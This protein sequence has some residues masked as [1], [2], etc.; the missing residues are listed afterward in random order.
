MQQEA[1]IG[2]A[3]DQIPICIAPAFYD[4]GQDLTE[5]GGNVNLENA[6]HHVPC[7]FGTEG[8]SKMQEYVPIY[9][10]VDQYPYS[11]TPQAYDNGGG[12]SHLYIDIGDSDYACRYCNAMLESTRCYRERLHAILLDRQGDAIQANVEQQTLENK[13][14]LLVTRFTKFDPIPPTGFPNHYFRFV[15]YNRLPY[16]VVDPEDKARKE[17][18]I[19]TDY[20]GCYIQSGEKEEW[21]NPNK[22]QIVLRRIE[23]QNLNR[24][25]IELTLWDD[26]GENFPKEKIDALEK[27]VIMAV[28]SC[29]V[30]RFRN[31]L[32]LASTPA[33]YYYIDPDIP[34]LQQYKAEYNF[35]VYVNDT[36]DT[37]MMTFFSPKADDIVGIDC[38]ALVNS[39][40]NPSPTEFPEKLLSIIGK[41]QIFQFHYNT[42]SKQTTVDFILDDILDKPEAPTEIKDKPSATI[43]EV[44]PVEQE[45]F[46]QEQNE[47][48]MPVEATPKAYTYMHTRSRQRK[49]PA[50]QATEQSL[51]KTPSSDITEFPPPPSTHTPMQ[52][53]PAT[54]H[55][56]PFE[57]EGLLQEENAPEI[58]VE[59]TAKTYTHMQTRS[60]QGKQPNT[61]VAGETPPTTDNELPQTSTKEN[62]PESIRSGTSKRHLFQEK[63]TDWEKNKKE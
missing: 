59:P 8:C 60:R 44:M 54:P 21:G 10:P 57:Q 11:F 50:T 28:S 39:L 31:N 5:I 53:A 2:N 15:S 42:S 55:I 51:P 1:H 52:P 45:S 36:T 48:E 19:L 25:S 49:Q 33:T 32:Q 46:L 41:T 56:T 27:P 62:V 14:P 34:E 16:K 20:I 26:L 47:P 22:D 37:A 61:Q 6:Y 23:I 18:P 30:T 13:T 17:Y 40:S 3:N 24:N 29:K 63:T 38:E 58:E 12:G 9:K 35:K 7:T 4:Y 43:P